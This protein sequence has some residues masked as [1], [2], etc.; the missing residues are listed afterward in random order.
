M[1]IATFKHEP[2]VFYSGIGDDYL[3]DK[4]RGIDIE[5]IL[6]K[7]NCIFFSFYFQFLFQVILFHV[8]WDLDFHNDLIPNS[9][10]KVLQ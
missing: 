9:K 6:C 2:S 7:I 1:R 4:P 10:A 3:L 5:V 8:Q